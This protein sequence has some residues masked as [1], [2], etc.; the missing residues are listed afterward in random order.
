[1]S[2]ETNFEIEFGKDGTNAVLKVIGV[3]GG[4]GNAVNRMK[5]EDGKSKIQ[6]IAANTDYQALENL[7]AD[8]KIFLGEN[9]TRGLGAGGR[10]EIG[11]RAA[12]ESREKIS[13]EISGADMLFITTGMGGGTGTGA[14]PVIADIAKELNILTVGVVTKP[15]DF[16]GKKRMKNALN[17]IEEL[18]KN[19]DTLIII[20][21]QKLLDL[22][23]K[24]ITL[25]NSFRK[26]DEVL[27]QGVQGISDLISSPGM[28]NL[29]F[30]DVRTIMSN[31]GIAHMGVGSASGKNK[32]E[33]AAELAIKSPLLE[34]SIK[35]AKS[36]LISIAGDNNLG[37]FD[38]DAAA[39]IIG[40]AVDPDAEIIF[41][42]TIDDRLQD[43]V[44]ITVIA[45]GLLESSN[46]NNFGILQS[47]I[48]NINQNKKS[49][50]NYS[51]DNNDEFS[52]D[53]PI[54]LQKN[55]KNK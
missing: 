45:T 54:F 15:F 33:L 2:A 34:T 13:K 11:K 49:N 5:S 22:S 29:D 37:L 4:G 19:I 8:I 50:S 44:I 55:K 16:E 38:T 46:D 1:M 7:D 23:D 20:P 36:V 3:G 51:V 27:I 42:T 53:I 9:F 18:K 26:A 30:A 17:G 25:L 28:I 10:P 52:F 14:A 31:K 35:G 24:S 32:T 47:E 21:N 41:G 48:K 43:E 12:E 39:K 40:E 6:Y